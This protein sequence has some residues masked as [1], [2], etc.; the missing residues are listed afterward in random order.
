MPHHKVLPTLLLA[1]ASIIFVG[2]D[3]A[4]SDRV[5]ALIRV[6]RSASDGPDYSVYKE[7]QAAI[8]R[9]DFVATAALR[10]A[11]VAALNLIKG[12][13]DPV[14]WL[15]NTLEVRPQGESELISLSLPAG[16]RPEETAQ[17]LNAVLDAYLSEIVG[18]ERLERV[19]TLSKMRERFRELEARLQDKADEL[20]MLRQASGTSEHQIQMARRQLRWLNKKIS[21][22]EL[23]RIKIEHQPKAEEAEK[24]TVTAQ[25]ESLNDKRAYQLEVLER[26]SEA[27]GK[28]TAVE[29]EVS[30]LQEM[31]NT[32]QMDMMA[33]EAGLHADNRIDILHRARK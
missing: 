20:S 4:Q 32:L 23:Q 26:G 29:S 11:D 15:T 16:R 3:A 30:T 31:V 6:N 9:S 1:C 18:K 22:F 8:L 28:I 7:T 10:N 21:E 25:L 12:K 5:T 13:S 14:S 24:Q 19:E 27:S 33:V 17:L 2:C